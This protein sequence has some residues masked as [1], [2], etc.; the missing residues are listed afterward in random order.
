MIQL[1]I[2]TVFLA[3]LQALIPNHWLPLIALSGSERWEKSKLEVVTSISASS[4][5]LGTLLLGIPFG[6]A[7]TKIG[8][9]YENYIHLTA[10]VLLVI[11]GIAY[12]IGNR[13]WEK[14]GES[15]N[16]GKS[17]TSWII[18]FVLM[19]L[20]SPCLEV[21]DLFI[22]AASYGFDTV[23]LFALVYAFVSIGGI[24][25]LVVFGSKLLK[26]LLS[27]YLDQNRKKLTT[28]V[29]IVVGILSVFIH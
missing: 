6:L 10:P 24:M 23:L 17:K 16:E 14:D 7:G 29:L 1:L 8:H 26:N 12:F 2:N 25:L 11:F 18:I 28:L 15:N 13:L 4:H 27:I 5:V 9:E 22:A 20:V 19:M 21:H 3:F